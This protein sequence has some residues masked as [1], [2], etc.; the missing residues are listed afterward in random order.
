MQVHFSVLLLSESH[1][2]TTCSPRIK[3]T[4]RRHHTVFPPAV[5]R[6]LST[7]YLCMFFFSLPSQS[8]THSFA[9]RLHLS[10]DNRNLFC[11]SFHFGRMSLSV[12]VYLDGV[13]NLRCVLTGQQRVGDAE[14]TPFG[15]GGESGPETAARGQRWLP[16]GAEAVQLAA[17]VRQ[18]F[19]RLLLFPSLLTLPVCLSACLSS[20]SSLPPSLLHSLPS[21]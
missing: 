11:V 12:S 9:D 17:A 5:L 21:L 15:N 16:A 8:C 7:V 19:L 18:P 3:H 4:L 1:P 2:L 13:C 10:S 14:R 20:S 6:E